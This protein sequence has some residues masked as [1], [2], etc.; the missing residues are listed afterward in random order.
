MKCVFRK[1]PILRLQ[2]IQIFPLGSF[3]HAFH[4]TIRNIFFKRR[5]KMK[6][7][8]IF[9][10]VVILVVTSVI[11]LESQVYGQ[12]AKKV[13]M[14]LRE[15]Y[16]DDLDF[17]LKMEVG[18]MTILLKKAGFQVDVATYS[19]WPIAGPTAKI[20]KVMRLS[21][22]NL[23]D[24]AGIII[25]CMG[26][27][28]VAVAPEAFAV[29]K[30]AL[31]DGKPVAA[32]LTAVSMLAEA[33]LLK[34]KKYAFI[35]DPLKTTAKRKRPDLRFVDAIYSGPGVVQDGKIITSGGCPAA[36]RYL[37]VQN[38]TVE[39]TQTFIAAMGP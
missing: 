28:N 22:I 4:Q 18:V 34:G 11:S 12:S 5:E 16:S 26:I 19:G 30:K 21:E 23:D 27:G 17:M 13:L 2:G 37:G 38:R 6:K 14:F 20:E 15:G 31:A 35:D 3:F 33:G 24:Y 39:L 8:A 9:L 29:V 10:V 36:E 1:D 25:P 7:I 32:A